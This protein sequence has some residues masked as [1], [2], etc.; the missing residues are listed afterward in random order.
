M[1]LSTFTYSYWLI[2]YRLVCSAIQIS[3]PFFERVVGECIYS[4][5]VDM[6]PCQFYVLQISFPLY[7]LPF[8]LLIVSFDKQRILILVYSN[9]SLFSFMIVDFFMHTSKSWRYYP[10]LTCRSDWVVLPFTFCSTVHVEL[11]FWLLGEVGVSFSPS[12]PGGHLIVTCETVFPSTIL[13]YA[14]S[15]V[16]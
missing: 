13:Q 9:L 15:V 16:N 10:I 14:T 7:D 11:A 5:I 6:N 8:T 4:Y 12:P 3:C 1:K 2:R